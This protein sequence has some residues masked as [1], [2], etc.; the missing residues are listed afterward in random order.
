MPT[1]DEIMLDKLSPLLS[2]LYKYIEGGISKAR[3]FFEAEDELPDPWLF[4]HIVRWH[5]CKRLDNLKD[6]NLSYERSPLAM[7]GIDISYNDRYVKVFKADDGELPAAGRSH[8]RQE[9]YKGNLFAQDEWGLP[10]YLAVIWD[11][12]SHYH[13]LDIQLVCPD[14]GP[15]WE[16]GQQKWARTIPHPG[17][18]TQAQQNTIN[19]GGADLD[20]IR[21]PED[22]EDLN[23]PDEETGTEER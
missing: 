14:D 11:V 7:S 6:P 1:D 16:S 20:E 19:T 4:S 13:L 17:E 3:L 23:L 9:F 2:I 10:T 18:S 5:I 12:N 21:R 22:T 8:P 15:A